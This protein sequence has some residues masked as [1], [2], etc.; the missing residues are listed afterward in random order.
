MLHHLWLTTWYLFYNAIHHLCKSA[1]HW[2]SPV[3]NWLN[4]KR[5]SSKPGGQ[6]VRPDTKVW[7]VTEADRQSLSIHLSHSCSTVIPWPYWKYCT[8]VQTQHKWTIE[9]SY[10]TQ[11]S[12]RSTWWKYLEV[13]ADELERQVDL[14]IAVL[15]TRHAVLTINYTLDAVIV[16]RLCDRS[17]PQWLCVT[18]A[19]AVVHFS[20]MLRVHVIVFVV[21]LL[22]HIIPFHF[23]VIIS[24]VA[25]CI[26]VIVSSSSLGDSVN[27]TTCKERYHMTF[28]ALLLW[29]TFISQCSTALSCSQMA[30][31]LTT[32][33]H[34]TICSSKKP[35]KNSRQ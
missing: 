12:W 8:L 11:L 35:K 30:R 22:H 7:F 21:C 6:T 23:I 9:L 4:S 14:A 15:L 18:S 33:L 29:R 31:L 17:T 2:P 25:V 19:T 32:G 28:T 27:G 3:R 20:G 13:F 26:L 24:L 5:G 1:A 10:I 34:S 16:W